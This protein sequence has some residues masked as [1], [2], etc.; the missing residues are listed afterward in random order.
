MASKA[1]GPILLQIDGVL[2]AIDAAEAPLRAERTAVLDLQSAVA[3]EVA[4]SQ[5]TLVQ[6]SEAQERAMGGLLT[7]DSPPIWDAQ[8]WA[9]ARTV[10]PSRLGEVAA[11]RWG[12]IVRYVTD[13]SMR[14]PLHVA[15]VVASRSCWSWRADAFVGGP[16]RV[17]PG[18]PP[19]P[20]SSIP[21][22]R[23]WSSACSS[24]PRRTRRSRPPCAP[25]SWCSGSPPRSGWR[26]G[27]RDP[28][29]GRDL[30]ML[31]IL[32]AVASLRG[33]ARRRACRSSRSSSRWRCS[34]ASR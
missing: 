13:P 8:V 10:L 14:T 15:V 1:P 33:D 24:S 17:T 16:R 11:S 22:P 30:Y 31:W 3:P 2:T 23:R 20:C 18:R 29:L 19:L 4:R 27:G 7:R 34:G 32:F 28:R 5:A 9:Q 12:D 6:F 21:I 25:C 26:G